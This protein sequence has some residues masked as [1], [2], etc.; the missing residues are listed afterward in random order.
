VSKLG[1]GNKLLPNSAE[2][3]HHTEPIPD[4]VKGEGSCVF[5]A[6]LIYPWPCVIQAMIKTLILWKKQQRCQPL[7]I[8]FLKSFIHST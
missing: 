1:V 2:I 3:S 6:F 4:F 5:T 7:P 8:Q